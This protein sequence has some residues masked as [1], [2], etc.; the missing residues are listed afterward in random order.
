MQCAWIIP[1]PLSSWSMEKLSS[2]KPV[3]GTKYTED[4]CKG[5]T[6]NKCIKSSCNLIAKSTKANSPAK[7]LAKDII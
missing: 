7:K 6:S 3:L 2:M 4:Y 1:N 5:L